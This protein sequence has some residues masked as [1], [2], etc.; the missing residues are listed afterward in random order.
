MTYS[1]TLIQ[2]SNVQLARIVKALQAYDMTNPLQINETD[3]RI[4]TREGYDCTFLTGC[5]EDTLNEMIEDP[6][7]NVKMTHGWTL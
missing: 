6:E 2:L 5:D 1:S 7:G 3:L 4:L